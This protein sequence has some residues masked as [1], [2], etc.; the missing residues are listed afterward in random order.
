MAANCRFLSTRGW[1]VS[2]VQLSTVDV[3]IEDRRFS[4]SANTGTGVVEACPLG[5]D[6]VE[7]GAHDQEV[8]GRPLPHLLL[9]LTF[10]ILGLGLIWWGNARLAPLLLDRAAVEEVAA[11]LAAGSNYATYD[12]NIE[13]R[14]LRR[15]HIANLEETPEVAVLGASHWQE[16]HSY[17]VPN[18]YFYNAHVHRDYYED[19][20]AVTEMFV[21]SDRLPKQMIITIRDNFFTPVADRTDFLWMPTIPDYRKM[22]RRLDLTAHP[23]V[24]TVPWPQIRESLSLAALEANVERWANAPVQPHVTTALKL[25]S[26][27]ILLADGSIKWS[28]EHDALFTA[29]Y[30]RARALEFAEQR[31]DDPPRIDPYG[32][33]VV[34]RLL[35]F[36]D[37]QGVEVFL[38]HP[39]FNP[40]F[41][42]AVQGS[43]YA[44][45]LEAIEALTRDFA[46]RHGL[47]IIGSFNPHDLGCGAEL[48]IDAEHSNP[49]CLQRLLNQYVELDQPSDSPSDRPLDLVAT[50]PSEIK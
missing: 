43:P 13:S 46:Q 9:V 50:K 16:A 47:P 48:Y 44:E 11:T 33:A 21:S 6:S 23:W 5:R 1:K 20:L 32:V 37:E 7:G 15:A 8:A 39:P 12:L 42:D 29:E 45:G 14:A 31:R 22:A 25:D 3:N 30:A 28:R 24:D 2:E 19:V 18:R 49:E 38:A 27:D 35:T 41:Y 10:S 26:L 17:L 36:L 40:I 4:Q 34:D